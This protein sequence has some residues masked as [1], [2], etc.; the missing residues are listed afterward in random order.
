[1]TEIARTGSVGGTSERSRRG[2]VHLIHGLDPHEFRRQMHHPVA[3][4]NQEVDVV[5]A[6]EVERSPVYVSALSGTATELA[7]HFETCFQQGW[8][9]EGARGPSRAG[10][11]K[12]GRHAISFAA[13][14]ARAPRTAFNSSASRTARL[15]IINVGLAWPLVGK[16]DPPA[17]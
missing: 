10:H 15:M 5:L 12:R 11:K 7:P 3:T 9:D 4:R 17:I 2:D 16:T 6:S 8:H 1:M 14:G 13:I